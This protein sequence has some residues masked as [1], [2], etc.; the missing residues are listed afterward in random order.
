MPRS[1]WTGSLSFGLVNVPVGLYSAARDQ[2][3]H[4]RQLHEK[5]GARI[6]TRRFCSKEDEEVAYEDIGHGYE[7]DSGRQV[8]LTDAELEAVAPRRTRTIEIES[9]VAAEE[10]DP[11]LYDHPYWL[12]ATGDSEGPKRAYRLLVEAMA[13]SDQVALGRFVL[14]TKEYLVAVRV[15]D[16]LLALTTMAF[17]DEIRP[18]TGIAPGGRKP[19]KKAVDQA[20]RLIEAL[21]DDFDPNAY[22]DEYRARL[23]NVIKAKEKGGT[24]DA[25]EPDDEPAPAPDLMEALRKSLAEMKG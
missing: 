11:I 8:V 16:G 19:G 10:I 25:P 2:D 7:L 20:V 18:T 13:D 1:L 17:A 4:F 14:R 24:I 15:R 5:D 22:K 6:E 21:S 9:F 12:V 23:R 3:L